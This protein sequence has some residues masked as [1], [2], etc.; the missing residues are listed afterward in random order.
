MKAIKNKT[1]VEG[2][3]SLMIFAPRFCSWILND[4][5]GFRQSHIRDGVAL[6]RYFA[7]LQEQLNN[8]VE[9]TESEGADQLEKYRSYVTQ[10]SSSYLGAKIVV[11]NW[12]C[13]RDYLST[14]SPRLD[15]M[16]VRSIAT[17]IFAVLVLK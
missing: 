3:L 10:T 17:I 12:T 13:S 6:A 4:E 1:E 7:W 2:T 14:L 16:E 9:L 15:P 8:G 5:T 11:G